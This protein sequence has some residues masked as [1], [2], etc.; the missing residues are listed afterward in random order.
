M[1]WH[2][3]IENWEL[4]AFWMCACPVGIFYFMLSIILS[5]HFSAAFLFLV[6]RYNATW[7]CKFWRWRLSFVYHFSLDFEVFLEPKE[8]L[9]WLQGSKKK[10]NKKKGPGGGGSADS[11]GGTATALPGDSP[12]SL[13]SPLPSATPLPQRPTRANGAVTSGAA[14]GSHL[15][16]LPNGDVY[17]GQFLW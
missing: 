16:S 4:W 15:S 6:I 14:P 3:Y 17:T 1:H 9:W 2:V 7:W 8:C 13:P 5:T 11:N 10:K 12:S